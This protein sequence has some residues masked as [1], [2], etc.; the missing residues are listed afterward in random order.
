MYADTEIHRDYDLITC[1][2][3]EVST[4]QTILRTSTRN[5][6]ILFMESKIAYLWLDDSTLMK[7][8]V[9]YI[10]IVPYS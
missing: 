9:D 3:C 4:L 2:N 6:I 5:K 7:L 10:I 8:H 1:N